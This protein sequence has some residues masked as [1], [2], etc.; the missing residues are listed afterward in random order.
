MEM[1]NRSFLTGI[2]VCSCPIMKR[3]GSGVQFISGMAFVQTER[4]K[5]KSP[6][7][8]DVVRLKDTMRTTMKLLKHFG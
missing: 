2:V 1:T 7:F 6:I 5:G 8:R 3:V 4:Y